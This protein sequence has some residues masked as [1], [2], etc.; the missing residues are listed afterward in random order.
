[1]AHAR[2]QSPTA[3]SLTLLRIRKALESCIDR[4]LS[5]PAP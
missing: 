5:H 1:M 3:L 2:R 4:Q